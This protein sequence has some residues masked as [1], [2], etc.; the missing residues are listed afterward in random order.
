MNTLFGIAL[1]TWATIDRECDM[2]S[3]VVAGQAQL[4]LGHRTGSL[5]LVLDEPGLTKL[6][7]VARQTLGEMRARNQ[8][9]EQPTPSSS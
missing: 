5:Q 4:T 7:D 8:S 2:R 6:V 9:G 3:E 1:D